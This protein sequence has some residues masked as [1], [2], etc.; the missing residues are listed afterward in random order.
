MP[1]SN[2]AAV[3]TEK[4][5][6][7]KR[8]WVWVLVALFGVG[9]ISSY[10]DSSN[11]GN[12]ISQPETATT[13]A[14][15]SAETPVQVE[16]KNI[17]VTSQ[18]VKLID[19]KYRYFFDIRNNDKEPF[20][21]NVRIELVQADGNVIGREDFTSTKAIDVGIGNSVFFDINTGPEPYFEQK[22]A[23]TGY[24]YSVTAN[25]QI[26]ASGTGKITVPEIME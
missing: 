16:Q 6:F 12:T 26:V 17:N 13:N 14:L 4:K 20:A 15:T 7:Y 23:V 21:G 19:K 9:L 22:Y 2:D 11:T 1:P 3:S 10:G 18:T 25:E 5:P 8:L 24:K